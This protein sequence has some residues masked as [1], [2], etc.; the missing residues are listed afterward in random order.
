M[1]K[2]IARMTSEG[3]MYWTCRLQA[4]AF[5]QGSLFVCMHA[6]LLGAP[7]PKI[8]EFAQWRSPAFLGYVDCTL[9]ERD[10]VIQA[11]R[12]HITFRKTCMHGF[13]PGPHGGELRQ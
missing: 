13:Y 4:R 3:V 1:R 2:C 6:P 10:A 5:Q 9:L 7:L 11:G 8:I 12:I